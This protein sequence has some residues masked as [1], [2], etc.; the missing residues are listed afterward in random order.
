MRRDVGGADAWLGES[1]GTP[2]NPHKWLKGVQLAELDHVL[3]P[4]NVMLP[5]YQPRCEVR[6][7]ETAATSIEPTGGLASRQAAFRGPSLHSEDE[8]ES[9]NDRKRLP[10]AIHPPKDCEHPTPSTPTD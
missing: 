8:L 7:Q 5:G 9:G 4:R 1:G 10:D 2:T 3:V 6:P